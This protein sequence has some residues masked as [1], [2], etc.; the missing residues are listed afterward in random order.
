[1]N[2]AQPIGGPGTVVQL[3][4]ADMHGRR[5]NH[6]GRVMRGNRVAPA[7]QNYGNQTIGPQVFGMAIKYTNAN[8]KVQMFHV[9]RRDEALC[10]QLFCAT[11]DQVQKYGRI[12]GMF[13]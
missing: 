13:I 12:N 1:M 8:T 9:L 5:K 4:E 7:R 11:F 6:V 3:D 10:E 2:N